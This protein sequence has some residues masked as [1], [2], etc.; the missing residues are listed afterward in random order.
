MREERVQRLAVVV[1]AI[2]A[3]VV[4]LTAVVAGAAAIPIHRLLRYSILRGFK[5]EQEK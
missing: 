4:Q 2:M 1:A 3:V 5:T